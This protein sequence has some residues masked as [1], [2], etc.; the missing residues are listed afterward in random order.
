MQVHRRCMPTTCTT[1]QLSLH[2]QGR[3]ITTNSAASFLQLTSTAGEPARDMAKY[4]MTWHGMAPSS[5]PR[6]GAPKAPPNTH[7]CTTLL[8][9]VLNSSPSHIAHMPSHPTTRWCMCAMHA[10]VC[11]C[12]ESLLPTCTPIR[13]PVC[14]PPRLHPHGCLTF[15]L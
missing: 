5:H 3:T 12:S 1:Q 7:V 9:Y 2:S 4:D 10:C 13:P 15:N 8:F 6:R 11:A 14:P